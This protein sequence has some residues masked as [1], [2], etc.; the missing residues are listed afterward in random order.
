MENSQ[1]APEQA[2]PPQADALAQPKVFNSGDGSRTVK[3]EGNGDAFLYGAGALAKP[4]YLASNAIGVQFSDSKKG[5]L[6]ITLLLKDGTK[7]VLNADGTPA[8]EVKI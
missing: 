6:K 2:Q 8:G 3:I 1:P 5:P 4:K 7:Q